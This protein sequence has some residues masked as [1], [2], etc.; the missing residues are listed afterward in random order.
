MELQSTNP[1]D[2]TVVGTI[3][4]STSTDIENAVLAARKAFEVW[5]KTNINIRC[6]LVGN[7]VKKLE[8]NRDKLAHLM[9]MEMG[10]PLQQ[11]LGEID[12]EIEFVRYY[13]ANGAEFLSDE[14]VFKNNTDVSK[15]TYE[16]YGVCA[17]IC[18]WNFPLS[19]VTSGVLPAIIAGNTVVVKPSEYTSLSQKL[20]IDLINQCDIPEGVV[21]T[22]I[23][24]ADVGAKLIDSNVDLV[25][26]T[27]STKAG[28]NIYKK[29]GEKFVKALLEMGG[30]S[31]G[32]VMEDAFLENA[33]ENLYWA[34]FLNC[35]QVCTA[36]KRLFV[37]ESIYEEFMSLYLKKI[38]GIKVGNPSDNNDIG[39]LINKKQLN[40]I[41]DQV[42]DA[43]T[44]GAEIVMGGKTPNNA[45]L[46]QGNYYE[47]TVITNISKSMRVFR[48]ETFGPVL[49]VIKFKTDNEVIALANDSEY[50]L[51]AEIY[52]SNYERGEKIAREIQSGTVAIN[53]D[54]FFRP[55]S[56]FGGYKKSG[57][58]REYGKIGMQEFS[59]VKVIA[60]SKI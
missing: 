30:S 46:S 42:L 33:V 17:C 55:E 13:S 35:G 50:G 37:H 16:P 11:S 57:S 59:Q 43:K 15:V 21:N 20:V 24:G 38:S 6:A 10:K 31:A 60:I 8:E 36:V 45:E 47:P 49:P 1:H 58:G 22:V 7:L 39:P 41:I 29:C 26:F 40:L 56:P 54:N 27:G 4:I 23:G 51:S 44:Q 28:L 2:Q 52:T 5:R 25:W 12:S 53:T 3:R 9:T 32:I 48:E 19:M 14:I 34:R 18:P